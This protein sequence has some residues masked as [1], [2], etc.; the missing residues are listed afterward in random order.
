MYKTHWTTSVTTTLQT[1]MLSQFDADRDVEAARAVL[2]VLHEADAARVAQSL[3]ENPRR[4]PVDGLGDSTRVARVPAR[5]DPDVTALE[6]HRQ[7]RGAL[8]LLRRGLLRL[9]QGLERQVLRRQVV[10]IDVALCNGR[11]AD[12][13]EEGP[14]QVQELRLL[15]EDGLLVGDWLLVKDGLLVEDRLREVQLED[16]PFLGSQCAL[17][18]R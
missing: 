12:V 8:C 2:A 7:V 16:E 4:P 17:G 13:A 3:A 6:F 1:D 14:V 5:L 15:R 11:V 10:L 18:D 9:P